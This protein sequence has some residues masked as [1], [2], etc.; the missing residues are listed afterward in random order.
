MIG[1]KTKYKTKY[2]RTCNVCFKNY[3]TPF[4]K[5]KVCSDCYD[6]DY[7]G[8]KNHY[9]KCDKCGWIVACPQCS[10]NFEKINKENNYKKN[11]T[12]K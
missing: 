3:Y 4:K 12:F 10:E 11:E 2:L 8:R 7:R 9:L 5:S 6:D 1:T